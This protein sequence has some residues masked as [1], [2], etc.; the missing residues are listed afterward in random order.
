MEE[1]VNV[2]VV[3][4]KVETGEVVDVKEGLFTKVKRGL[5]KGRK[6]IAFIAVGVGGAILG[7]AIT[8]V[9]NGK[10]ED[11]SVEIVNNEDDSFT[12]KEAEETVE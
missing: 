11:K 3:E 1:N 2:E 4:T 6:A 10:Y 5:K 12:V 7:S 8:K 9:K